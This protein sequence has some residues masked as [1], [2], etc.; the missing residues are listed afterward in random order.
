MSKHHFISANCMALIVLLFLILGFQNVA[1]QSQLA[2]DTYAIFEASCLNCHGP[3][4]AFRETLL[5]EHSEL[6]DGGTVVPGNP[7]ASELYKRLLGPTENGVQMPFG[8]PQLPAQS[9]DTI[10]RWILAGAPEWTTT[11][12]TDG[13]F[14]SPAEV[15][16][17]IETH[18]TSLEPFDRAFARYF[19]LTHLYNAGE[20]VEIL[21]EYRKAL[22]K[23]VNSLSW[24]STITNPQPIDPQATIY[25][26]D[27]RHFEWDV[28]DG[29]TKIEA[30]YPYHI[31]FDTQTALRNQ[32]GR[33]QTQMKTDVPSVHIDWFIANASTPPLYHDLLSLPLT[34]RDLETRLEVDVA[35]NL[36]N[37][38]GVRVWRA[39]FNNSGVSTNNRVVERHT[40]RYG[41]YWKSYDFAGSV[42]TQNI[43]THPLNFTHDGGE[44]V[45]NL[46]NGL[47]GY[48]LVN[49]SGF[50]LDDAP[51]NIVSNPAA[52]DPTVRN[53]ISC[54]G[55]H[56]E[57]MK[58]F[59]DEVRSVIE[60]NPN[61]N[62]NK[63]Q[64]LRLYVEKSDMD[65]LVV[66]D[67]EKFRAALAA[68]GGVFG[69]VETVSRFHEAFQGPIDAAYA[70]AV[71]G[72][73]TETFLERVRENTG[74]Q[75][76]GL[77]AL[78]VENGS[79]NRDT[80]TSSFRDVMYALDYPQQVGDLPDVTQPD[81]IPGRH[82]LF[83][84][85]NLRAVV[86]EALRKSPN[87]P[88]TAEEMKS[89]TKLEA[90][91]RGI[92]DLTG[93]QFA[94]NLDEVFLRYNQ[95]S[96]LSPI[97]GAIQLH[98]LAVDRNNL[99]DISPLKGLTNL[100]GLGIA[101]NQISDISPLRGLTNLTELWISDNQISD[102]SPLR[103]MT[104]L[105]GL[106]SHTNPISDISPVR[107]LT[108]LTFLEFH[109]TLVSDISPVAG[110]IKLEYLYFSD[111]NVSDLSSIAGLINLKRI[112]AWSNPISRSKLPLAGLTE[113]ERVYISGENISDLTPLS[114]STGLK[115]LRLLGRSIPDISPIAK[116]T[117]LEYLRLEGGIYSD[118]SPLA[119]LTN[120]TTL[121]L[122]DNRISD[123]SPLAG[124]T[125]LNSLDLVETDIS[126]VTPLARLTNLKR[127]HLP[128]NKISDV[129][130]LARLTN[131]NWLGLYDNE[132]VDISPLDGLRKNTTVLWH[133]NPGFP[134]DAPKI[135]GPWLW[136][137]LRDTRPSRDIDSLSEASGGTVTEAE[138]ST[139]GATE[140]KQVGDGVWTFRELPAEGGGN[141]D[142]MLGGRIG[143]ASVYG[144]LSLY[145]PRE[146]QTTMYVGSHNQFKVWLN[147]TLIYQSLRYH[148]SHNYTDFL[149]VTL[150]QG[151]NVLL[152]MVRA[153]YNA[154]FGFESG[155]EYTLATGIGY[156]FS[157]QPIHLGDTFTLNVRAESVSDLAGWQFD[158][159]FDP[160]VLEAVDMSEGDFLKSGGESTFFQGGRIDNA[161]GKITGL[162]AARLGD[163]GVSGSGSVL[164]VRFKAKSEG[165]TELALQ[166]FLFGSASKESIPAGPL[167]IH[168]TVEERLL[169]GDVNRDGVVN[170]LDLI[171][172]AQQ[173]GKRLPPNSPEDINGD[174]IVNIFDLT[175]VAQG[176]GGAAAPPARGTNTAT[177]QAWIAEARLADDGSIAFRQ[178]IA[179]LESLLASLII[180]QETALLANYPNPFNPE[181]WIPY[182]LAA[183]G[184]VT[185]TIYDTNGGVVR[186]LE[187]GHQP[188]GMYQSRSRAVYWDG[189]ND[190]G[191]S[192]ASG[193]YFYTLMA[194]NFTATRKMLIRK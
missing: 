28:N 181:T 115:R 16:T 152:V 102:I 70:A 164:Q 97:A 86:V 187:V 88:I 50:R 111:C 72:L 153:Q 60:S 31:A 156:G 120:L 23:L 110:L 106:W 35:R 10:R 140:G 189:R 162:S 101:D 32:L 141:V 116:L 183:P 178:G 7:D 57:G 113:L 95:I 40:S 65:A 138:I 100:T 172:V 4:G 150:R 63:A 41:A 149:P 184:E 58:T 169:T 182:Q 139:H 34:D 36:I 3:D 6:I 126:N 98:W 48:Y 107:G 27:L 74:L 154:F 151:K 75:N 25:Y 85:L 55:C 62:Y 76:V 52:S 53:G 132:I 179:N 130:P 59:E 14:I 69:G 71:V 26:I 24:G 5:M 159:A 96:D 92:R 134:L 143:N 13:R 89:L 128:H 186:R 78:E 87:A 127:L 136:V 9:I 67:M 135:R 194:G 80:W 19:T 167:E 82:V 42:G 12:I 94:T 37:A 61:P 45:F 84:D 168:I 66:K 177:I 91:S 133:I 147:G 39:G 114:N 146:Q 8:L 83:P 119:S 125:E 185:L 124:L 22:N 68:T 56:T 131:L 77:L 142:E 175:L 44:V 21:R 121:E 193:L 148:A 73:E 1:A 137:V 191:E 11:R 79:V 90:D 17:S 81:V 123:I 171:S 170:I 2:Q 157:K 117:E 43:L 93:L 160:A 20:T 54:I 49:A 174:G 112:N 38:P 165:E 145:S 118:V 29:W 46:P 104:N 51:I 180:P 129:R 103:G 109:H 64:A 173:L 163:R 105:T 47:Q 192:I 108:N 155:T 166:N 18:L 188:A 33:L 122:V 190:R 99:T 161:S 158:V 30:E 176:I 15:L 144:A